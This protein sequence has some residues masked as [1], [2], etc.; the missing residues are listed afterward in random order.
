MPT[1][2]SSLVHA[3]REEW[4]VETLHLLFSKE[5]EQ[6]SGPFSDG[7]ALVLAE[8]PEEG[9]DRSLLSSMAVP[10][11][12]LWEWLPVVSVLVQDGKGH[13]L[14]VQDDASCYEVVDRRKPD[15][16]DVSLLQGL[17]LPSVEDVEEEEWDSVHYHALVAF[18]NR[19]RT[20]LALSMVLKQSGLLM[21]EAVA[22]TLLNNL[23]FAVE[24]DQQWAPWYCDR[25]QD[26]EEYVVCS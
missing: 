9:V 20:A 2:N 14:E 24:I 11:T 6:D 18:Q 25:K 17:P 7:L 19:N 13:D 4:W 1:L 3:L 16:T 10:S 23:A 21:F 22:H 5:V 12:E 15:P 8:R 26:S